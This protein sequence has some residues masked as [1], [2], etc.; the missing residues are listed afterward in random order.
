MAVK[1]FTR[2]ELFDLVWL[3]RARSVA[4]DLGVSDVGLKKAARE[5]DVPTPPRGQ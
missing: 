2:R 4:A 1:Q 5:A 3:A